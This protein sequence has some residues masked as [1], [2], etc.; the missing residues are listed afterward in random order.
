M[1]ESLKPLLR[2]AA[3]SAF[4]V[5]TLLLLINPPSLSGA[6]GLIAVVVGAFALIL[7]GGWMT[8]SMIG[9]DAMSEADVERLVER[10]EELDRRPTAENEM[11]DFDELVA[12]AIDRLP[13][14]F[15]RVLD[16]VPIVISRH[17]AE[18]RAYG[19]YYGGSIVHGECDH[20]IVPYQDTIAR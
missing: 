8:V 4:I 5:G 2:A 9:R 17:G 14:E 20:R 19:H 12:D 3:I 11:T 16:A 18:F 1:L 6:G 13:P 10:S 15:Q 7:L